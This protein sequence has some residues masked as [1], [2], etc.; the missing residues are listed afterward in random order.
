MRLGNCLFDLTDYYLRLCTVYTKC[1]L[2]GLS[3]Q[4]IAM[5]LTPTPHACTVTPDSAK[6][7]YCVLYVLYDCIRVLFL[8]F[9]FCVKNVIKLH[10]FGMRFSENV[11]KNNRILYPEIQAIQSHFKVWPDFWIWPLYDLWLYM[12]HQVT[13]PDIPSKFHGR[14][15]SRLRE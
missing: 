7:L 4:N 8:F 11:P 15:M 2:L 9:L 6:F 3:L 1:I 10:F 5:Q 14:T 13:T 12:H